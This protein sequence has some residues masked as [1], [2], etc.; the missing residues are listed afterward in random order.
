MEQGVG[1]INGMF[2]ANRSLSTS[3]FN[4]AAS[5][6]N[7]KALAFDGA[8]IAGGSGNKDVVAELQQLTQRFN[9]LTEAV[10]NMQLVL[11]TGTL[12][13]A[14]S[15]KMDSQLGTLASRRGRGN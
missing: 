11:D 5:Y 15:A 7:V 12:V 13:G 8:R 3:M 2:A 1:V 6:R 9:N 14:T 10:M 4:D